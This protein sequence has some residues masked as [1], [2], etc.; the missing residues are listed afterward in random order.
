VPD[1]WPNIKEVKMTELTPQEEE[2]RKA[3]VG[4]GKII[5]T[6]VAGSSPMHDVIELE[7][8]YG[9][10]ISEIHNPE[11]HVRIDKQAAWVLAD[12]LRKVKVK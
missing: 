9:I 10:E 7:D 8:G 2:K 3:Y 6:I 11:N 1:W 5:G 4:K 12:I